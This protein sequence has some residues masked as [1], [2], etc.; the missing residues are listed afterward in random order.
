LT[1]TVEKGLR[2]CG[3]VNSMQFSRENHNEYTTSQLKKRASQL[4][5]VRH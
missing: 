3:S 5:K 2:T 1:D 4:E